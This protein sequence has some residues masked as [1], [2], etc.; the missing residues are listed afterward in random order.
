MTENSKIDADSKEPSK[1]TSET[2][3]L[4][5]LVKALERQTA[6]IT[7]FAGSVAD[8]SSALRDVLEEDAGEEPE[9]ETYLNGQP[10]K[11]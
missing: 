3:A 11:R 8:L 4:S 6:A 2:L 9:P 7:L 5:H 10:F 1:V